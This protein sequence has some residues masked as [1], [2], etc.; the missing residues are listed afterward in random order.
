METTPIS[1]S[2]ASKEEFLRLFVTQ[3]KNQ[4]PL[5]PLKGHEFIAQLAQFSSLEQLTNLNTTF[6]D[7]LKFQQLA[8]GSEFIGKKATYVDPAVGGTAEGVIQGAITHDGSISLVIQNREIPIS[9]II[10]I[11][12]NK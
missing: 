8:G 1:S 10:G 11:F 3:L 2:I 6:A 12:E 7:N 9:D 5:D 4:S